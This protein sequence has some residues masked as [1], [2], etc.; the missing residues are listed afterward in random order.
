MDLPERLS[1]DFIE[2]DP[3]TIVMGFSCD[4]AD[5]GLSR[6]VLLSGRRR[7]DCLAY[8]PGWTKPCGLRYAGFGPASIGYG[9]GIYPG[10]YPAGWPNMGTAWD[11]EGG[12]MYAGEKPGYGGW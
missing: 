7:V 4:E 12:C 8:W 9:A 2:V 10:A 5:W 11:G 1:G 3:S 6:R